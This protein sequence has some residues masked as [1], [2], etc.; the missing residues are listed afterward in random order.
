MAAEWTQ[1]VRGTQLL[2]FPIPAYSALP[3]LI[4]VMHARVWTFVIALVVCITLAVLKAKGRRVVWIVRR[5]H[6]RLRGGV[7]YA[8]PVWFRRRMQHLESF[9]L[10]ELRPPTAS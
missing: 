8:R 10:V 7:V 2:W 9:D 1:A 6:T 4:W 5:L 3:I